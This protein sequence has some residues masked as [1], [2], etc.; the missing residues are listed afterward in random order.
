MC[1]AV[2][3]VMNY[4]MLTYKVKMNQYLSSEDRDTDQKGS[5]TV[6]RWKGNKIREKLAIIATVFRN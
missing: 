5:G 4:E 6:D 2:R 1:Q 3:S